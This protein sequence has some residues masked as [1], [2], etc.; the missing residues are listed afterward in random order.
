MVES[1]GLVVRALCVAWPSF[2]V[3]GIL[4]A[5]VFSVLDPS[6]ILW[7]GADSIPWSSVTVHSVTFLVFW[8]AISASCAMSIWLLREPGSQVSQDEALAL[9]SQTH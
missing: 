6:T 1:K 9:M 4:E 3:A 2:L 7:F 8:G 5:L